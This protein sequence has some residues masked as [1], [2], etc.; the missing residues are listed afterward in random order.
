[1]FHDCD[2]PVGPQN[3]SLLKLNE[4]MH[5]H[6]KEPTPGAHIVFHNALFLTVQNIFVEV[7]ADHPLRIDDTSGV[8]EDNQHHLQFGAQHSCH[9]LS[10][11]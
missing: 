1:M 9:F 5:C 2:L 7:S 6:N 3:A 4:D 8:R 10:V 11:R